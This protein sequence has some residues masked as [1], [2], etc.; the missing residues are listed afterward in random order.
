VNEGNKKGNIKDKKKKN[1]KKTSN[2]HEQKGDEAWKKDPPKDGENTKNK[3]ASI[4]TI[5]VSTT[6]RGLSTS[7][8][9][10]S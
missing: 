9:T 8:L 6:W 1:K 7:L 5:G 10:A 4:L 3:L 2:Q